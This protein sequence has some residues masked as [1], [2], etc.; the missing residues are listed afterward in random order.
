MFAGLDFRFLPN[1]GE[2]AMRTFVNIGETAADATLNLS[3]D[4]VQTLQRVAK[5]LDDEASTNA[6][7]LG[8]T[9]CVTCLKSGDQHTIRA[10]NYVHALAKAAGKCGASFQMHTGPC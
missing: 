8:Y 6:L 5:V 1:A 10:V 7:A 4:D 9:A 2:P 3:D